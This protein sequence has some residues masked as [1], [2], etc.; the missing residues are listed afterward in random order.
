MQT[1][2]FQVCLENLCKSDQFVDT[3]GIL[4][5]GSRNRLAITVIIIKM[6]STK[7]KF[8]KP[9]VNSRFSWGNRPKSLTQVFVRF[10]IS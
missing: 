6:T 3:G 9:L 7:S 8:P 2:Q 4:L 1:C 10:L 5:G